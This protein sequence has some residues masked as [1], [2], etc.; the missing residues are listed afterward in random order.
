MRNIFTTILIAAIISLGVRFIFPTT[1]WDEQGNK[2]GS[3]NFPSSLDVMTNPS[4]GDSVQTVSHSSQHA[5]ANDSIEAIEAKVG[6]GASTATNGT[7]LFGNGVGTS[8]WS[9]TPSLTTLS[10]S[11]YLK[12][13]GGAYASSTGVFDGGILSTASSTIN[14]NLT[15]TG[16]STSTNA[17]STIFAATNF[18][19][20]TKYYGADLAPCSSNNFLTWTGGVFACSAVQTGALAGTRVATST[21]LTTSTQYLA[22]TTNLTDGDSLLIFGKAFMTSGGGDVPIG[23][24]IKSNIN[25]TTTVDVGISSDSA[26]SGYYT[27]PVMGYYTAT[28][29]ETVEVYIG[30]KTMSYFTGT[31]IGFTIKPMNQLMFIKYE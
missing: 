17:T 10:L 3:T 15:I 28:T 19:S 13:T 26:G 4:A 14:G 12:T 27:V 21:L 9:A 24:F 25:S 23:L 1:V 5:N 20:S 18:A 31:D 22:T 6:T 16:N 7:V 8:A 30:D 29:T 11:S 2:L